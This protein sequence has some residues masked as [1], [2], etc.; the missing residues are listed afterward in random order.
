A[1]NILMTATSNNTSMAPV[2][3][4]SR[5]GVGGNGRRPGQG[6]NLQKGGCSPNLP[7]PNGEEVDEISRRSRASAT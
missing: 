2:T 1:R 3:P 4:E 5:R 7:T 6:L